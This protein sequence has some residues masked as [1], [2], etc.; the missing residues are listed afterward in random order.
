MKRYR[1]PK[2][3]QVRSSYFG[4]VPAAASGW[5]TTCYSRG[6]PAGA[7]QTNDKDR[8]IVIDLYTW[9]TPNGRKASIALEELGLPYEAHA[10][11]I[12]KGDQFK[13]ES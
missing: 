2:H 3:K 4:G 12:G 1:G 8:L 5:S 10:I 6:A 9:T 7:D 13:P 11:D